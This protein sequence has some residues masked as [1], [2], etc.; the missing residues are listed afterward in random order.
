VGTEVL[1]KP[2]SNRQERLF[3]GLLWDAEVEPPTWLLCR[4]LRIEMPV[5]EERDAGASWAASRVPP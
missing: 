5:E 2:C 1:L 4:D 3:T